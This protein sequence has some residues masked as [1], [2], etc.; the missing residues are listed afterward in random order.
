MNPESMLK[1]RMA[2]TLFEE[3]M[4]QSGNIVY[5]FGYEAIAQNLTQLEEKFDRYSEVGERIRAIPDFIVIDQKGKPDFV[6]VKFRWKPELHRDDF[7]KLKKI[8][9]LWS[10]KLIFVNCWKQ[11]YFRISEP[12][13]IDKGKLRL[14]PLLA[15]NNWR[16][17]R[18][19]YDEYE[20]L[21]YKYLTPT[22]IPSKR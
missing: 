21:V 12:P 9:K 7:E 15:E 6:E 22:L 2:E 3:L 14:K 10:P 1:G 5:R 18:E 19:I 4:R 16:I 8:D 11:P 17:N 13:Y 20:R